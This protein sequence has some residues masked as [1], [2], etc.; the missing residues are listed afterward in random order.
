LFSIEVQPSTIG[1]PSDQTY[2]VGWAIAPVTLPL[3][4]GGT[5]S[6]TYSLSPDPPAG[7]VFDP[8]TRTLS[9]TPTAVAAATVYT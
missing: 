2:E 9:G 1:P 6:L 7:L 4:T 8:E 3:V 5:G